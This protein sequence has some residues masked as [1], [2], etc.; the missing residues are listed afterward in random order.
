MR[1][2]VSAS[3]VFG[4]ISLLLINKP[5]G[6][7]AYASDLEQWTR[8]IV[9]SDVV[10]A[11]KGGVVA[12]EAEHFARQETIEKRHWHLWHSGEGGEQTHEQLKPD[13]DPVHLEGA[14]GNAYLEILP[15]TRRTHAQ[16][17][18]VGEN[19]QPEPGPLCVLHY[20]V[21]FETTGRYYVWVR[22]FSTGGEDNGL[23]VGI[24]DSWPDSGKRMQWCEGKRTW[25]WE[26]RQRTE[27][28]HCGEPGKIFLDVDKPGLHVVKFCMREDGFEFD[29]W[30]ITTDK[31]FQRPADAGPA[32]VLHAGKLPEAF[33]APKP[34]AADGAS[35]ESSH[36]Q[37]HADDS[38]VKRKAD[39]DGSLVI[40]CQRQLWHDVVL[41]MQGPF[42]S[43]SAPEP[44]PFLDYRFSVTFTHS[45]SGKVYSVPG[46]FA[47][48]GNAANS[49]A[50][51][52]TAW[53]CHFCPD[54]TGTWNYQVSFVQGEQIAVSPAGEG[55]A[56][57][58]YDGQ[59]GTLE[60]TESSRSEPDFRA[61]G[62]LNY[63]AKHYLEFAA[64]G[65][66][67]FKV[68]TDAPET[69][70]AF[71]DFD[72]TWA[73][74]PKQSPVKKW[75]AHV[76]DWQAGDPTWKDNKG[77]GLVGAINY[78]AQK[79]L[80]S[81]SFL[82]YN[83]GGDG[84]NVW[85]HLSAQKKH[86]LQFDCSKLDQWGIC[87][88]HA[89]SRGLFLH[90]KLQETENDDQQV[91]TK[92][93][94]NS[95]AVPAALDGGDCGV[96][97]KLYLRELIARYSHLPG[98][99]WNLG[100]ENTQT[101]QQQ[102][103]MA[104]FILATD[105]Y[106]H[107]V[108]IHSYPQQQDQVYDR[109]LGDQSPLTGASLQNMW[110]AV[111]QRTLKWVDASAK[112]GRPWVVANDEQ[113]AADQGVPPDPGY[114]RFAGPVKMKNG[115][116]YD[117][118]DIR[119]QTL[120]G[121]LMAGGAGVMYY[122]G[123]KLP[124][125]DLVCEDF[126]SRDKSWDYCGLAS[127]FVKDHQ[128]P[129]QQMA[130]ADGLVG[131][132][133]HKYGPWCLT[134]QQTTWLVYL[135]EGN[136]G[137]SPTTVNLADAKGSLSAHWFDPRN[138][139]RLVDCGQSITPPAQFA[140]PTPP[141]SV[142]EDWV[143]LI[144]TNA[145]ELE[146]ATSPVSKIRQTVSDGWEP[147]FDAELSKWEKF[148]GVPHLSVDGLPEGTPTS[149]DG[150]TGQPLGLN[151]DPKSIFTVEEVDSEPV[152]KI[153]GEIYGG[154]T[155]K[156]SYSNYHLRVQFK[157]GA[158]KY[159]PRL[160]QLRDSGILYHCVG[161]HG[162]FWN[163]WMQCLECQIQETDYGDFFA[164]A[165]T[166]AAA[167]ARLDGEKHVFDASADAHRFGRGGTVK[168][169]WVVRR[170]ED[171]ADPKEWNTVEVLTIGDEAL[172]VV[173]G[174]VV[175]HLFDAKWFDG[176]SEQ[177]LDAGKLQLQSEAAEIEYRRCELRPIDQFPPEYLK[178]IGRE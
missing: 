62:R 87:F 79:K 131:N 101:P 161:K 124:E 96:E 88:S 117:L 113:G 102:V 141:D 109:L 134:D 18:I 60:I 75:K 157:W 177:Q 105:P 137:K 91:G 103:A 138:G 42:A 48:D 27:K 171:R 85:P 82:T 35:S 121:N 93:N 54:Q 31:D 148:I 49:S 70:L 163:V 74:K 61:S 150:I 94:A 162:A 114:R 72:G 176:Q 123:Y 129:L 45:A 112:A 69:M 111:H 78:L 169:P 168:N 68:G 10:F 64:T 144:R 140:I 83:V 80:N 153:S 29:R 172:H 41:T 107:P 173:N 76:G 15:D 160:N 13:A 130:N 89:Q 128:L 165:G 38:E 98:L 158:K 106:R 24:D 166:S 84:D 115:V 77:R 20:P 58:P 21:H 28:A 32:T 12:V 63:V 57:N 14:S 152:L 26:S 36:E 17:L 136:S 44:N 50:T 30:L 16:K 147:L 99:E 9:A 40:S 100:E 25:F 71:E 178:Q 118:H 46:Y 11:E 155:T 7:R 5:I 156:Q 33:P 65:Q 90:F 167:H 73:R 139:G 34:D 175:N 174:K 52:G 159:A 53:R 92:P 135:P 145:A 4:L 2:R 164:L 127:E 39:G 47:A 104:D 43:E 6:N 154:L 23:H 143:L 133:E 125:S 126:R 120:W 86:R 81:F 97:R 37:D 55:T 59:T 116:T 19:F 110:N 22:C 8:P 67:F 142:N 1:I 95:P 3:L 149:A 122:F 132:N 108:V 51:S 170:S 56:I 119:K 151:N 66:P 146:D